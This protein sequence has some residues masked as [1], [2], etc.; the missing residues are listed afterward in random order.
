MA[1]ESKT[2]PGGQ[3]RMIASEGCAVMGDT[4]GGCGGLEADVALSWLCGSRRRAAS[5]TATI[6][7]ERVMA[8]A[9]SEARPANDLHGKARTG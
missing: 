6:V 9:V 3:S 7:D 4:A 2:S 5:P 1:L 8:W